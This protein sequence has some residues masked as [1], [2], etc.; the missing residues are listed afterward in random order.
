VRSSVERVVEFLDV[1]KEPPA[2]IESNRVPAYWPSS[3]N[4]DSLVV[5][6]DLEVKYAPELPSVLHGV[7]FSLKARERVGLLG[8]TGC[9]KSTLVSFDVFKFSND[10]THNLFTKAM[11]LLRFVDPAKGRIIIDGIDITSIGT[12]DLRSRVTFIPQD[13]TLF[14]GTIRFV[15]YHPRLIVR[16]LDLTSQREPGPLRRAFRQ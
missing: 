16:K 11:S 14:A 4:S 8:R 12:H 10:L 13:A 5:V 2:V 9:G 3:S 6:E 15:S 7:S 1:P